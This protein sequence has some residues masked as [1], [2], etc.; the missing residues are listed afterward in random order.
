ML[1]ALDAFHTDHPQVERSFRMA[2]QDVYKFTKQGDDRRIV[3][4]TID[5]GAVAV[6]VTVVFY[7]S[8]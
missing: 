6:G 2:V 1:D 7:P 5:Y 8:G 4:G 3:A